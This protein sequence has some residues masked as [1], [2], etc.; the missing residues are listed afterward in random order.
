MNEKNQTEQ[1]VFVVGDDQ[2]MR[3]ALTYLFQSMQLPVKVFSSAA[4][5]LESRRPD[6]ASCLVLDIRLPG[7]SGLEFQDVLARAGIHIPLLFITGHGEIR[8]S[9]KA[10]HA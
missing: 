2:S 7:V 6:I 1:I 8:V 5:L 10:I 3:V 9:V 4:E